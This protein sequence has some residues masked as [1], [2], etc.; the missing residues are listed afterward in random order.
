MVLVDFSELLWDDYSAITWS[1]NERECVQ[2][3]STLNKRSVQYMSVTFIRWL[4]CI[5]WSVLM[6][7]EPRDGVPLQRDSG[8]QRHPVW[9]G[10]RDECV[11][12]PKGFEQADSDRLDPPAHRLPPRP[13]GHGEQPSGQPRQGRRLRQ[14][15]TVCPPPRSWKRILTG[16]AS[17]SK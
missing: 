2:Q 8:Q 3:M 12:S 13:H 4:V 6:F 1:N 9:D 17:I 10:V 15:R 16:I 5:S 7:L 14:W 11:R